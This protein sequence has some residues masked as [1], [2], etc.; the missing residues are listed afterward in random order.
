VLARYDVHKEIVLVP[1]RN[2]WNHQFT[3]RLGQVVFPFVP[4]VDAELAAATWGAIDVG[5]DYRLSRLGDLHSAA[6]AGRLAIQAI[7]DAGAEKLDFNLCAKAKGLCGRDVSGSAITADPKF[8]HAVLEAIDRKA[9]I[10][11]VVPGDPGVTSVP[12][13]APGYLGAE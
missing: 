2:Y 9:I 6:A 12:R 5:F 1:N 3:P 7:P 4:S 8:R 10:A 11:A 13:D